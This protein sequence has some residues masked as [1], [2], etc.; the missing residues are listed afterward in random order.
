MST[1]PQPGAPST[2]APRRRRSCRALGW[3]STVTTTRRGAKPGLSRLHSFDPPPSAILDSGGG[4][5][6]YWFLT[7]PALLPDDAACACAAGILRGLFETLAAT[8][9]TPSLSPR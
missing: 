6:A 7:E 3:T 2:V 9:A 5:H 4:L 1:S 8:P